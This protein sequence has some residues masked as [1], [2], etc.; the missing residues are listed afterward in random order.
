MTLEEMLR[1]EAKCYVALAEVDYDIR[2]WREMN[3]ISQAL[4][5]GREALSTAKR[6][7]KTFAEVAGAAGDKIMAFNNEWEDPWTGTSTNRPEE[8]SKQSS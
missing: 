8:K 7:M 1:L 3:H 2:K 5:Q 4:A 6:L